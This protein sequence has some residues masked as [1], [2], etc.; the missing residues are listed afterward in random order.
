MNAE[1]EMKLQNIVGNRV[2]LLTAI[3]HLTGSGGYNG[4]Y[5]TWR[6]ENPGWSVIDDA[7]SRTARQLPN[8]LRTL[9]ILMFERI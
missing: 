5:V 2:R 3:E 1:Y 4:H 8:N 7:N 6:R 9:Q